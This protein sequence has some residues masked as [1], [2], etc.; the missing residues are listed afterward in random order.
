MS[1]ERGSEPPGCRSGDPKCRG[2]CISCG[3]SRSYKRC[4]RTGPTC[5]QRHAGSWASPATCCA[6]PVT[7]S[8]SSASPSSSLTAN[9]AASRRP[10]WKRAS[11]T[12]EPSSRCVDENW[13]GSPKSKLL[14]GVISQRC[15]R[16]FRSS[17]SE[18]QIL[19]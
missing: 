4:R 8:G 2:R 14:S 19:Y 10:R 11:F 18:A 7:C 3:F 12:L 6:A 13:G 5:R 1:P 15:S 16:V 17:M 9:T